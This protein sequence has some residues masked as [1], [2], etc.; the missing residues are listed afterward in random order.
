MAQDFHVGIRAMAVKQCHPGLGPQKP[1]AFPTLQVDP[2]LEISSHRF[3]GKPIDE[4]KK[5]GQVNL[6]GVLR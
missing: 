2:G 4:F 3:A 6:T 5:G 1:G